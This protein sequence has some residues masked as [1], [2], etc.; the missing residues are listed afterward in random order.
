MR[1][2]Q[3]MRR[4]LGRPP[5]RPNRQQPIVPSSWLAAA[6]K[7][8]QSLLPRPPSSRPRL[9]Q[10]Q[11][12]QC[13][14]QRQRQRQQ[15]RQQRLRQLQS[16]S[17]L[18]LQAAAAP[19]PQQEALRRPPLPP[20]PRPWLQ[21]QQRRPAAAARPTVAARAGGRAAS[22][23]SKRRLWRPHFRVSRNV[24]VGF[25]GAVECGVRCRIP[26]IS[27]RCWPFSVPKPGPSSP[28]LLFVPSATPSCEP[29]PHRREAM[30]RVLA[31]SGRFSF[32]MIWTSCLP[33]PPVSHYPTEEMKR[34]LA[35]KI[36][37]TP[38][39]VNVSLPRTPPVELMLLAVNTSW[40]VTVTAHRQ[41]CRTAPWH[42]PCLFA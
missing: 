18:P 40:L 27:G 15:Q 26:A 25:L 13:S 24:G 12:R 17:L 28:C 35:S 38:N 19:R 4:R 22:L 36:G 20:T 23:I 32:R 9:P 14:Q 34:V 2:Q 29:P 37:L 8:K 6:A 21:P 16:Q 31:S 33:S 1:R 11:T 5:L 41:P 3:Q 10:Q 39:Q 7:T 30:K 42:V